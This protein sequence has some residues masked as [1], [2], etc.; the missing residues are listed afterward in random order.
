MKFILIKIVQ[1]YQ[2]AIS[3]FFPPSCRYSPTCSSYM[4][5][6]LERHGAL[7]GFTMGVARILRC[8]PFVKGGFDPVPDHFT[9]SRNHHEH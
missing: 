9:L 1:F 6:A 3:P 4:V 2:K 5:T 8:N 7:K